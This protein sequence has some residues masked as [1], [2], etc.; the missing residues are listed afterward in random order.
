MTVA[1]TATVRTSPRNVGSSA[2]RVTLQST[3]AAIT[4]F[5]ALIDKGKM[6]AAFTLKDQNGKTHC[7]SD[8]AGVLAILYLCPT[9]DAP[10]CTKES[11]EFAT[12]CRSS[13][14]FGVSVLDE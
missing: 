2:T 3:S 7:L 5:M 1:Y 8:Y 13:T 4:I 6:A 11:C 10:G 12:T 14:V 9:D